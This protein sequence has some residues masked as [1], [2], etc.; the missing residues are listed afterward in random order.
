[1]L[2]HPLDADAE[3]PD[4]VPVMR[5]A[6]ELA[7]K[8]TGRSDA[9]RIGRRLAGVKPV[10]ALP[11]DTRLTN[12]WRW[13]FPL[14]IGRLTIDWLAP[15]GHL[16]HV[17]LQLDR[18]DRGTPRLYALIDHRCT[19]RAARQIVYDGDGRPVRI[20]HLDA[21]LTPTGTEEPI[22]PPVPKADDPGGEPVAIVD[23]GV[24][25]LLP[26]I[27][28]RLARDEN[29][30]L[31][32]YDFWDLDRRPFDSNPHRSPFFPARHGTEVASLIA[33]EAPVAKLLAYRFP[34]PDMTR[35]RDLVDHAAGQGVRVLNLSLVSFHRQEWAAL[36]TAM[37]AHPEM[38]FVVAAG[39]DGRHVDKRPVFPAAL[40][41]ANMIA[42]TTATKEGHLARGAN[43]GRASIDLMVPADPVMVTGFDGLRRMVSGSSYAAAR[44]T[45]LAACLL[46]A[47]PGWRTTQIRDRLFA[48]AVRP[49]G[50]GLVAVGFMPE[51]VFGRLGACTT[52][53][54]EG[55]I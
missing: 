12:G 18:D 13:I 34:R 5:S 44:V 30:D 33:A 2:L 15:R 52:R 53:R 3:T 24:N 50:D 46:A 6:I 22:D 27:A 9:R 14:E 10:D 20:L 4:P 16:H 26:S 47:Y 21:S 36:E 1:M 49:A 41:H 17:R 25:Y 31:A 51:T 54:P 8:A 39:N 37:M 43:W 48:L 28:R 42:V 29:G 23:T 11:S 35:F 38:L 32:G 40:S 7:C 19:M 45:A 55:A